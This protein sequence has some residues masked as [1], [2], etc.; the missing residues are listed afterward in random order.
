L[1]I[2]VII[3]AFGGCL[4]SKKLDAEEKYSDGAMIDGKDSALGE[5]NIIVKNNITQF[6]FME[7]L[8]GNTDV[9]FKNREDGVIK[10]FGNPV[11][12]NKIP[13]SFI[14]EGGKIIE[15]HE[16]VY[17]DLIH[18]YYIPESGYKLYQG[19]SITNKLDRLISINIGDT[20]EKLLSAFD[21]K[22]YTWA[23]YEDKKY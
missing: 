10:F 14:F 12:E 8:S 9:S 22:Y 11:E 7:I 23:K 18:R 13:V 16:L 20:S 21:D 1:G 4:K 6:L 17:E 19:F 2:T 3:I 5:N 15:I